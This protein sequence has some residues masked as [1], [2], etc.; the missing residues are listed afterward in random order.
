VAHEHVTGVLVVL[1]G[2][3]L[4][5]EREPAVVDQVPRQREQRYAER[6]EP[7]APAPIEGEI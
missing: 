6:D 4:L 1:L 7:Q 5:V 2:I 3:P